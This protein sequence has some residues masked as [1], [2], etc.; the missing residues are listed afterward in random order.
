MVVVVDVVMDVE[1]VVA[2]V[3]AGPM[4]LQFSSDPTMSVLFNPCKYI[5]PSP[6]SN[7]NK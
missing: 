1:V 7:L 6:H 5:N 2:V 4:Y 3:V